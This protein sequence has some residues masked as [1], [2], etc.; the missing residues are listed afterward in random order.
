T[1]IPYHQIRATYTLSTI[2]VYQAYSTTIATA[3][4]STQS[5]SNIP[6][7]NPHRM[8]WIKPSF[9][10]M[11]YRSGW[12]SKPN[13]ERILAIHLTREGWEQALKWSGKREDGKCVRVQWDPE[14]GMRFEALEYRSI[15]V[16][17]SGRAVEEGLFGGW[18]VKIEDVTGLARRIGELVAEGKVAEARELLP[19]ETVYT[20]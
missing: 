17:L 8:T 5:L 15:Q 12:A 16:G 18:I 6:Q 13:Q 14:R 1:T 2:T 19:H 7:F 3:A 4:L 9:R 11:L 10:W 20:F